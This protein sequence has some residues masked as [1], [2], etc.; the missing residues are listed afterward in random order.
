[1]IIDHILLDIFSQ[2]LQCTYY[3][4]S[5]ITKKQKGIKQYKNNGYSFSI[6]LYFVHTRGGQ[7]N[8]NYLPTLF[9]Q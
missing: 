5:S 9:I 4:K 1:M 7:L 2:L 3:S 8:K 6:I